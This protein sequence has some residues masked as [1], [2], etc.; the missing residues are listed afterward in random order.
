MEA[1][2]NIKWDGNVVTA[3]VIFL[4]SIISA[5]S[6]VA[7]SEINSSYLL[8][9][10]L[11]NV[12]SIIGA[13]CF[14]ILSGYFF[15][16]DAVSF[17]ELLRKKFK[18]IIIPWLICGTIVYI[19]SKSEHYSMRE[20]L[21]FIFG[22]NSYLYYMTVLIS[23]YIIFYYIP[24]QIFLLFCFIGVNLISLTLTEK[25]IYHPLLTNYLNIANWTG[26]FSLGMLIKRLDILFKIRTLPVILQ[27]LIM[28]PG[29]IVVLLGASS[30]ID[31]YFH[32]LSFPVIGLFFLSIYILCN[33]LH[34]HNLS[35]ISDIGKFSFSIYLLHLPSVAVLKRIVRDINPNFYMI[36]PLLDIIIFWILFKLLFLGEKSK[37]FGLMQTM[38]GAR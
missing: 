15:R 19:I 3:R 16:K 23:C 14:L 30:N 21:N 22:Y 10:N 5:H 18:T 13:P 34:I 11:W 9:W 24:R 33:L 29:I 37:H 6:C 17:I 20:Y 25:G 31:S 38:I 2:N 1:S 7:Q 8:L 27:T 4:L 28:M 35:F 36:I 26:Y 32:L 12:W